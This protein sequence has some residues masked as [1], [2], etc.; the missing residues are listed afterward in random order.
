MFFKTSDGFQLFYDYRLSDNNNPVIVLLNGLTQSTV[1]WYGVSQFLEPHA[2]VLMLDFVLQGQSDQN[3][4]ERDFSRHAAD[5]A[6]LMN[7]LHCYPATIAG[8]SYGSLV[9]QHLA[10]EHPEVVRK[11][12]LI[13]TFA[14]KTPIYKAIELSWKNA[15]QLGGYELLLDVMLPYVLGQGY[16]SNPLI[17]IDVLKN[18]RKENQP[19]ISSLTKLMWATENRKDYLNELSGLKLPVSIIQGEADLLFP[20]YFAE[21][22]QAVIPGSEL[23]IIR[24]KGHTLNL[25]AISELSELLKAALS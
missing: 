15:L 2:N 9:A 3:S 23:H 14:H 8:I 12:V 7:H 22:I 11:L 16:F 13:S 19:Q 24:G 17:P 18:M 21:A 5:V 1:S 6:E 4:P 25:E 10:V 20:V